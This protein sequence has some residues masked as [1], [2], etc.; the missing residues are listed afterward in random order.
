MKKYDDSDKFEWRLMTTPT[1]NAG[2]AIGSP[3]ALAFF[4]MQATS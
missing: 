3:S 2:F 4:D 1:T